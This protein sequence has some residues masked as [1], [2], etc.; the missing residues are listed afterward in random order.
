MEKE[1]IERIIKNWIEIYT[2]T[3]NK[4][5]TFPTDKRSMIQRDLAKNCYQISFHL[6][7]LDDP[8]CKDWLRKMIEH[9]MEAKDEL[10]ADGKWHDL[11]AFDHLLEAG[12]ILNDRNL[13]ENL[14]YWGKNPYFE[15]K[16]M[17][18]GIKNMVIEA[19]I[20]ENKPEEAKEH[21]ED[22]NLTRGNVDSYTKTVFKNTKQIYEAILA[23]DEEAF[24][25]EVSEMKKRWKR[26][27]EGRKYNYCSHEVIY[28]GLFDIFKGHEMKDKGAD[29]GEGREEEAD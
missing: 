28:R 10:S 17:D 22:F 11:V 5:D 25:K 27:R 12:I 8:T 13:L 2:N 21:L 29:T 24:E 15:G 20:I 7:E 1:T 18:C 19:A 3:I 14:A 26:T 23:R 9:Y 16:R 4:F 6:R